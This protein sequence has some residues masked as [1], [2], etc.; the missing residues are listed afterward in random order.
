M[1]V[2]AA[3]PAT[4]TGV[5]TM[6]TQD[7]ER[8]GAGFSNIPTVPVAHFNVVGVAP[9]VYTIA[10][11]TPLRAS[12]PGQAQSRSLGPATATLLDPG[13]FVPAKPGLPSQDVQLTNAGNL[14]GVNLIQGHHDFPGDYTGVPHEGSA[15]YAKLGDTLEL[16][17]TNVTGAHHPFHLHGFSIQPIE[18]TKPAS[19]SFTFPTH[20]FRDN[21]DIPAGYTLRYRVRIDDRPL[22]DGTTPGGGQGP[23][24][25]PLPHLLPRGIRHDFRVRRR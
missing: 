3:I 9:A 12:I 21:I 17:V 1:D 11:G 20:E 2:V 8:T 24:G 13:A 6:W 23:M 19:P 22:M 7:F 14:L 10:N 15:R 16:T 5:L 25:V 4:A 18:F